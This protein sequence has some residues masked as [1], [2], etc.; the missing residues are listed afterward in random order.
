MFCHG[1]GVAYVA[2]GGVHGEDAGVAPG[3]SLWNIKVLE[4]DG[5]GSEENVVLGL[6]HVMEMR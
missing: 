1:T 2:A 3:A 6:E 5:T 4:D